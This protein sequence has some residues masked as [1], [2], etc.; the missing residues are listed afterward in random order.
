MKIKSSIDPPIKEIDP[1]ISLFSN[2]TLSFSLIASSLEIAANSLL[3]SRV[4]VSEFFSIWLV[5]FEFFLI[6][7]GEGAKNKEYKIITYVI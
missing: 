7:S 5:F 2:S 3:S 4:G 1:L 6:S